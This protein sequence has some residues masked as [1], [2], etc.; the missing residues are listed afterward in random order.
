MDGLG[1][2]IGVIDMIASVIIMLVI[3]QFI[4]SLLFS[5][6]VVNASNEFMM[7]IYRSINSL[8]DPVLQPIRRIMPNTGVIDFSPIVLILGL[9][10][11]V[12]LLDRAATGQLV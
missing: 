7:A 3:V 12:F 1:T 5:F 4:I 11:I 10:L 6:N 9:R 8:L 2:L